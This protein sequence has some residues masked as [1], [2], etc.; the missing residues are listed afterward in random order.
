MVV[1]QRD[2]V[3]LDHIHENIEQLVRPSI[4]VVAPRP[5]C[6]AHRVRIADP[7]SG[8][9]KAGDPSEKDVTYGFVADALDIVIIQVN[10][11]A[12]VELELRNE[13]KRVELT[14]RRLCPLQ[15]TEPR[16][17]VMILVRLDAMSHVLGQRLQVHGEVHHRAYQGHRMPRL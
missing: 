12:R 15:R 17:V 2:S 16:A 11:V 6:I 7:P 8:E 5:F 1:L 9:I 4:W 10:V 13:T 14:T 3:L